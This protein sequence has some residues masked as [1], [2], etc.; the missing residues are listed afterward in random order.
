MILANFSLKAD[1]CLDALGAKKSSIDA[2]LLPGARPASCAPG[3][4][5]EFTFG[6]NLNKAPKSSDELLRERLP[7]SDIARAEISIE[8]REVELDVLDLVYAPEI[9]RWYGRRRQQEVRRGRGGN[10]ARGLAC[11]HQHRQPAKIFA[12]Q[13]CLYPETRNGK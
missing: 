3:A 9:V 11:L 1:Q 2:P 8:V 13:K 7:G 4:R 6:R 5:S 10:H 12:H